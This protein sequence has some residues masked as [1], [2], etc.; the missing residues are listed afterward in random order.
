[1]VEIEEQATA[2]GIILDLVLGNLQ[3]DISEN[4][5]L[6]LLRLV[7]EILYSFFQV[8]CKYLMEKKFCSVYE[9]IFLIG[10]IGLILLGIFTIFDYYFFHLDNFEEYFENFNDKEIFAIFGFIITQLG[11]SLFILFTNKNNTP[12]HIFIILVFGHFAYYIESFTDSIVKIICLIFILFMSLIFCEII[13]INCFGLS[14]NT[15]NNIVERAESEV[16][17]INSLEKKNLNNED[18]KI[19]GLNNLDDSLVCE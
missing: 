2:I 16:S 15:K 8:M 1:M 4:I 6:Y 13:Q 12:C 9:I 7:R 11:L 14:K 19:N 3:N 10:L 18:I 5:L 17:E